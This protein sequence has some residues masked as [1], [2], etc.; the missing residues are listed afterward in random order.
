MAHL[1]SL[2]ARAAGRHDCIVACAGSSVLQ[3]APTGLSSILRKSGATELGTTGGLTLIKSAA[4]FTMPV[5]TTKT[6]VTREGKQVRHYAEVLSTSSAD[7]THESYYPGPGDHIRPGMKQ[8]IDGRVYNHYWRISDQISSLI[9]RGE[10]E[11]LADA[12]RA[13]NITYKLIADT[14]NAMVGQK[15]G[16]AATPYEA[17]R[18]AEADLAKRLPADLGTDPKKWAAVLDRL[19]LLTQQRDRRGWHSIS[20]D[21]DFKEGSKIVHPVAVTASTSVGMTKA[22]SLVNY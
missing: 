10:E 11:H 18:L 1:Q 2:A 9:R 12:E 3:Q 20:I 5:F 19:L 14:I 21:P 13:Y 8:I 17:E 16:P 15:Y 22:A 7:A 6:S 4:A